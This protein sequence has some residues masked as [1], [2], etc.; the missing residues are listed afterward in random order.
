MKIISLRE[1]YQ[2]DHS[3]SSYQF[4][5]TKRLSAEE[6]EEIQQLTD[7]KPGARKLSITYW[8][9]R[10]IALGVESELL[11]KYF[12]VEISESYDWWTARVAFDYDEKLWK[13]LKL[14]E[15]QGYEDLGVSI[16]KID[17]RIII[18]FYF[19]VDYGIAFSAFEDD[20][21]DGLQELFQE[22][23]D[24]LIAGDVS[25][26]RVICEFYDAEVE[27]TWDKDTPISKNAEILRDIL[28]RV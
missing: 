12:D 15:G 3:S 13:E 4:Y 18:S 16:E 14:Y 26:L 23:R 21:F 2:P 19:M 20:L 9:E 8:G 25:A 10:G 22:I 5:T 7:E 1:G 17:S 27:A 24:E 11:V 6:R 28:N